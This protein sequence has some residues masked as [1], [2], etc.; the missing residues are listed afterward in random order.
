ML[1]RREQ[2]GDVETVRDIV[3]AAFARPDGPERVPVEVTLLDGLRVDEGWLPLLS[4]VAEPGDG[5]VVGHVVC[6]RGTVDGSPALGLGPL[7]VRPD[8]QRRGVGKALMH[9][10]LGAADALG[11]P[12]VALL[13]EPEYYGRYGFRACTAYGIE[14][15]KPRWGKYFQVR[16]LSAYRPCPGTFAYAKPFNRF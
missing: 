3:A 2:P 9:A 12:L 8:W 16:T 11:E 10:V 7:A 1:V 5:E 14:P 4:L 15:P 13:G 6:T